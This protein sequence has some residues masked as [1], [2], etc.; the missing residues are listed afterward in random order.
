MADG[1]P[2]KPLQRREKQ[3]LLSN[4]SLGMMIELDTI[5]KLVM[6]TCPASQCYPIPPHYSENVC[7]LDMK[8]C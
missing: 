1:N 6:P 2:H 5:A 8:N 3:V 7:G 4:S